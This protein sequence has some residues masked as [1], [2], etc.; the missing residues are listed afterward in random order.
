MQPC[1]FDVA[2]VAKM[3]PPPR[4]IFNDTVAVL[5]ANVP[6]VFKPTALTDEPFAGITVTVIGVFNGRFKQF[7]TIGIGFACWP[8]MMASG[9]TS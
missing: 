9:E 5:D 7:T 4:G 1:Q 6:V 8:E 3:Y 2:A